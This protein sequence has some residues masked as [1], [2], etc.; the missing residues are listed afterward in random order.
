[1]P[2]TAK[3]VLKAGK[4]AAERILAFD[5]LRGYFLIVILFNHLWYYPSGL[6]LLTGRS[7]LYVSTAE[8]FFVVS[9]IVLGIVRGR[10]LISQP[11]KVATR[12][13]LKRSFHLYITSIV[14]TILFTL[15]GQ[16]FLD[17]PGLK[18]TIFNDIG[19]SW[20]DFIWQ[21]LTLQHTYGWA[22][23]LRLYA[24]FIFFSPLALWLLRKGKWYI[25]LAASTL[26]WALYPIAYSPYSTLFSWQFV[27][28]SGFIIGFY[29]QPIIT[30]W[31]SLS[32]RLRKVIGWTTVS[33]F[34]LTAIAT[35]TLVLGPEIIG[36]NTGAE[37]KSLHR[38]VEQS[39]DKNRLSIPRIAMGTLWF[40]ALFYLV[41]RFEQQIVKRF[42]WIL[43]KFGGNSLY[44][45]IISAFVI[46]FVNLIVPSP[47]FGNTLL[48]LL[49]SLIVLGI[50]QLAVETK[51]LMK[52]IP[53]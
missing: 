52:I 39:F 14:L 25:L 48:N 40:W 42:G 50:V 30:K 27:F 38:V 36:G 35:F 28:F 34:V 15:I 1:M 23:F 21:V 41:R 29:W 51:F 33:A 22:D 37:I 10:R 11:L 32:I 17:N 8:G 46:F 45:Y 49:A 2:E 6:E 16:F 19:G 4:T 53:R 43:L 5:I 31:R 13:L 18:T 9:G 20:Y 12:L 24:V 3:T 7:S 26:L 47:G 44:V